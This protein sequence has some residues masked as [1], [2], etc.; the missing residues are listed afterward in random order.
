MAEAARS[1]SRRRNSSKRGYA[2]FNPRRREDLSFGN[3]WALN[4][5]SHTSLRDKAD[6]HATRACARTSSTYA[7][8]LRYRISRRFTGTSWRHDYDFNMF[9]A[10][11]TQCGAGLCC[12]ARPADACGTGAEL[13]GTSN[14]DR[15][16]PELQH[17]SA[18]ELPDSGCARGARARR[19]SRASQHKRFSERDPASTESRLPDGR[20]A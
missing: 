16:Q 1:A 2:F 13:A 18:L 3:A 14:D 7:E 17:A 11:D 20:W 5:V 8:Q 9:G 19:V 6:A 4:I 10:L 15:A 12:D